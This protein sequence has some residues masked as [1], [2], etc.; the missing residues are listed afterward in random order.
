[1]IDR[2]MINA[3]IVSVPSS[4][5]LGEIDELINV[6]FCCQRAARSGFAVYS[7]E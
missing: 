4:F 7:L 5:R 3:C 6:A 1:M 2:P